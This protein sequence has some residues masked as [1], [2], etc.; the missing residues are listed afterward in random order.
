MSYIYILLPYIDLFID[1]S[2]KSLHFLFWCNAGLS[3]TFFPIFLSPSWYKLWKT[4]KIYMKM[5][6]YMTYALYHMG[7]TRGLLLYTV[8]MQRKRNKSSF[9]WHVYDFQDRISSNLINLFA[10]FFKRIKFS[11]LHPFKITRNQKITF[12]LKIILKTIWNA[13][14]V[15]IYIKLFNLLNYFNVRCTNKYLFS[16]IIL[17]Q[18]S[19]TTTIYYVI[20]PFPRLSNLTWDIW[21][22][23]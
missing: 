21:Q 19:Y 4:N 18:I 23:C 1:L 2:I 7:Q 17:R 13:N 12:L 9:T 11:Y 16:T 10:T 20:L 3:W 14:I 6:A 5:W 22:P 15:Y 8:W